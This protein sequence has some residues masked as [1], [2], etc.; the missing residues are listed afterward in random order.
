MCVCE[1]LIINLYLSGMIIGI[2]VMYETLIDA[3][4]HSQMLICNTKHAYQL[5]FETINLKVVQHTGGKWLIDGT[6]HRKLKY[7]QSLNHPCW[8]SLAWFVYMTLRRSMVT[9]PI[10]CSKGKYVIDNALHHVYVPCYHMHYD[11]QI[12]SIINAVSESLPTTHSVSGLTCTFSLVMLGIR[13]TCMSEF[14]NLHTLPREDVSRKA[15]KL[16]H[17]ASSHGLPHSRTTASN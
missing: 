3:R 14:S 8:L 12:S 17:P 7:L 13:A 5:S 6:R 4:T 16:H 11:V 2:I 9:C 10:R 1:I 15:G